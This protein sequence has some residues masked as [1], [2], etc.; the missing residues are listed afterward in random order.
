MAHLM[1]TDIHV[2]AERLTG[3]DVFPWVVVEPAFK[4]HPQM[5]NYYLFELLRL[6]GTPG[7]PEDLS[8]QAR[9]IQCEEVLPQQGDDDEWDRRFGASWLGEHSFHHVT[10]DVLLAFDW[11]AA[12][13]VVRWKDKGRPLALPSG[14][15]L[16][17]C[18]DPATVTWREVGFTE[19]LDDLRGCGRP[20]EVRLLYGFDS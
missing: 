10:L 12:M 15:R 1:G 18:G 14:S 2:I 16:A 13:D 8:E 3:P 17:P 11:D 19:Y 4:T 7:M 5:R 9:A 20:H 6:L